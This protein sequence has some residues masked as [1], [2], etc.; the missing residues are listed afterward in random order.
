MSSHK[1]YIGVSSL[2]SLTLLSGVIL[3]APKANADTSATV[4][5]TVNVPAACSL[6]PAN[7]N[8]TKT[9]NPG[10]S[11]TIGTSNLKAVCNDP[12]G[13]AIYAIGYTNNTHGNTDLVTEL[14]AEH[15]I[16]TGTDTSA[17]NWNMTIANST[18]FAANYTADIENHFDTPSNIPDTYTKIA[19]V[20]SA[21]DQT[22][23]TNLTAK[24][25]AYIAPDQ[26]AGTYQ[27]KVKF[28]LVH[29]GDHEAPISRPAT[30]DIGRTVN[31][32]L[33]SLAATV[34]NGTETTI[35]PAYDPL[36][37][38][39]NNAMDSYIKAIEVHTETAAPTGFV[40][41]TANTVSTPASEHPIYIVFDN[42][43]D[44]GIMHFYTEGD[45]IIL[46]ED[47]SYMFY[48][49]HSISDLSG[50]SDWDT[51]SVMDMSW[52]FNETGSN[53]S[54]FSLDLSSW[55]TSSVTDM[56]NMFTNAGYSATTWSISGLSDWDTSNVTNMNMM[57]NSAGGNASTF[58]LDLSSWNTSSVTDMSWMFAGAGRNASTFS[59]D[60][61]DWNTSNVTIIYTMFDGA[62]GNAST[63]S[64]T[65][66]NTNGD[67]ISNTT[68]M[69]YGKTTS[70]C[71][72]PASGKSFTLAQ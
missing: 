1:A 72:S 53:A 20:T 31:S 25:D 8:L 2:L 54:T 28:T 68:G 63:W 18:E 17:S 10:T 34:V 5:L 6:T 37:D 64:V 22:I 7:T 15:S 65:I 40:A 27:G 66:P 36:T 41:S 57:F 23:G 61:S 12:S 21:T 71:A 50:L 9:I 11:D 24:F 49:L 4:D 39:I 29:P 45:Q 44:A 19:T 13:F 70:I 38:F 60:L 14:G 59:L 3:C 69:M 62:G 46:S 58:S 43:N 56:N 55:N 52:M 47:A 35:T 48:L 67:G 33:M 32:K 16:H 26:I 42:T 30:L 51:S